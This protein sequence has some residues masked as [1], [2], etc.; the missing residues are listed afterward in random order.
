M[1]A[2]SHADHFFQTSSTLEETERKARKA[3]NAH[4]DPA[5]F[6]TKLLALAIDHQLQSRDDVAFVAQA[7]GDINGLTLSSPEER[8]V[9]RGP[10]APV[11]CLAIHSATDESTGARIKT[12]YAGCWD[13]S[14]WSFPV[15]VQPQADKAPPPPSSFPAHSDFV[16]SLAI[17]VTP[18]KESIIISGSADGDVR[19]WSL[20]GDALAVVK[21]RSRAVEC[22]AV[23]P[24]APAD[25]PAVFFGTSQRNIF[26]LV[27]PRKTELS[28]KS[29]ELSPL[30]AVHETSVY[31]LHFDEDGDLWTAS[32]DR[33]SKR[34]VRDSGWKAD[35]V[36]Q[37][38]DFVKDVVTHD[39]YGLVLTACRDEEIRVWDKATSQLRHIFTGHFEEVTGLA[40]SGDEL[41]SVSID[42]T[43]RRWSLE[44][45]ALQ[46]AIEA[47]K[48]VADPEPQTEASQLTAEEEAEL[49]ALM[50]GEEADVLDRMAADEQ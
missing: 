32:A 39:R 42:A 19:F 29:I 34:L 47:V 28:G 49:R 14:V 2:S 41:I 35:T 50:E 11:T 3:T 21:A 25:A 16:K 1:A 31:K 26:S 30:P 13:K 36:L 7:A 6:S 9:L 4:G 37:H 46:K 44:P 17:A 12:V 23:D 22:I 20:S 27:L 15:S 48:E 10:K 43:L 40:L 24:F 5:K 18:D 38:P 33:S 45:R 8:T